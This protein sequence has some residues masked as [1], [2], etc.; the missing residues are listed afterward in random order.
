MKPE[1]DIAAFYSVAADLNNKI[2]TARQRIYAYE[3]MKLSETHDLS[4]LNSNASL[5]VSLS[6][7]SGE[8]FE[9]WCCQL[10]LKIGYDYASTTKSTGDFGADIIA[11]KDE[12]RNAIQC[13]RH[14]DPVGVKAIQEAHS[15]R[16]YYD[17]DIAAVM[18]SSTFTE[19]ARELAAKSRVKLWDCFQIEDWT[20]SI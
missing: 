5:I 20:E 18:T 10:L 4:N 12:I 17:C 11:E 6:E 9:E 8:E 7:M 13:K 19:A 3:D 1:T 14:T 2:N 15:A 16:D